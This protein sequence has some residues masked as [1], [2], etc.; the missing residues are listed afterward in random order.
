[1][2]FVSSAQR[3]KCYAMKARHQNG[4]WNCDEWSSHTHGKLPKHKKKKKADVMDKVAAFKAGFL[5]R[6]I[7]DGLTPDQIVERADQLRVQL[8]KSA[9]SPTEW[10]IGK[11]LGLGLD[12]A[13]A[14][15]L[16]GPLLAG[17]GAGYGLAKMHNA[18]DADFADNARLHAQLLQYQQAAQEAKR[19][20]RLRKLQEKYPGELVELS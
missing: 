4:S 7:E 9:F 3:G 18:G 5:L 6:A 2:P 1:M 10:L 19:Q 11:P 12:V 17:A 13:T 16:G 14:G 15:L 8:E 20:A